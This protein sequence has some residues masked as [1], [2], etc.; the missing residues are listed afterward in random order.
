M[1]NKQVNHEWTVL[2]SSS[3]VDRDLNN[4]SLINLIERLNLNVDLKEGNSWDENEGDTFPLNMVVVTRLRKIAPKDEV[5]T[6]SIRLE[7]VSPDKKGLGTFE[8]DFELKSDVDNIRMRFGIG[9]LR[10]TKS[11]LYHFDVSVKESDEGKFKKLY[12]L[13]LEVNLNI[14]G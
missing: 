3:I 8:N 5:V 10:L 11:G 14:S 9:A 6:G 1:K 13:P 2:C 7:F 4:L 12:S